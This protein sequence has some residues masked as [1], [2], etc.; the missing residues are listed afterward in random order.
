MRDIG[1]TWDLFGMDYAW[2]GLERLECDVQAEAGAQQ[3][4]SGSSTYSWRGD[5]FLDFSLLLQRRESR[6]SPD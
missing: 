4:A 2:C 1:R 3:T 6:I 5:V